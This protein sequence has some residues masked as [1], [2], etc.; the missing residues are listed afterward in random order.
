HLVEMKFFILLVALPLASATLS[1]CEKDFLQKCRNCEAPTLSAD[2][3]PLVG[4]DC[5]A[6]TED[7][8]KDNGRFG[9][10]CDSLTCKNSD[11]VL[12]VDGVP[13]PNIACTDNTWRHGQHYTLTTTT[14]ACVKRCDKCTT[15]K[16]RGSGYRTTVAAKVEEPTTESV[17]GTATCPDDYTMWG[18]PVDKNL[19]N[20][21]IENAKCSGDKTWTD[22]NNKYKNVYC[23][24]NDTV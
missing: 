6:A 21:E 16:P 15:S 5:D 12:I 17:C 13:V 7:F 14:A 18:V 2:P 23:V 4:Y 10:D 19:N 9:N 3:C 24:P 8:K 1:Q 20:E 22:G 11:E